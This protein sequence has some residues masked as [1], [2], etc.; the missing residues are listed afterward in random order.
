[1]DLSPEI[2]AALKAKASQL[3]TPQGMTPVSDYSVG[4]VSPDILSALKAKASQISQPSLTAN[5]KSLGRIASVGQGLFGGFLDEA[6]AGL[7][8]IPS[9]LGAVSS[10]N[11][12][13]LSISDIYKEELAKGRAG[14][15]FYKE[16]D[17]GASTALEVGGSL[18]SPINKIGA[19]AKGLFGLAKAGALQSGIYG[20]GNAEGNENILGE[21]LRSAGIGGGISGSLGLAG[22]IAKSVG[23]TAGKLAKSTENALIGIQYSDIKNSLNKDIRARG[24]DID[25][26]PIEKAIDRLSKKGIIKAGDHIDNLK[27]VESSVE[28]LS[29]DLGSLYKSIDSKQTDFIEP[30][31]NH[32]DEFIGKLDP[33][34]KKQ[35]LMEF[36]KL[37]ADQLGSNSLYSDWANT[38]SSLNKQG[39]NTLGLQGSDAFTPELKKFMARD[40]NEALQAELNK[41][42][43]SGLKDQVIATKQGLSDG[44]KT[45][46][47]LSKAAAREKSTTPD[48]FITSLMRTSGGYGVPILAGA[49]AGDASGMGVIPGALAGLALRSNAGKKGIVKILQ[50]VNSSG[51]PLAQLAQMVAKPAGQVARVVGLQDSESS[52]QGDRSALSQSS[53]LTSSEINNRQADRILDP[54]MESKNTQTERGESISSFDQLKKLMSNHNLKT[55]AKK[56]ENKSI[57]VNS[58]RKAGITDP[59]EFKQFMA[60]MEHESAG[61]GSMVERGSGEKYEGRKDLGNTQKGDGERFKGRGFIQL[62]GR[63][64]YERYGQ[65]IGIDLVKN[66]QFAEDPEVAAMIA[67]EYWKDRVKSKVTDFK[68]VKA[69][70]KAINGGYN[71]LDDRMARLSKYDDETVLALLQQIAEGKVA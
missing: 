2:I 22:K 31:F 14:L 43:Y 41:P 20:A 46:E 21:T 64:N 63:D 27:N 19:G 13:E 29:K 7:S 59:D 32:V 56:E 54:R 67:I 1:M 42:H 62:T 40:I 3:G 70:T 50:G 66:P 24:F 36:N 39:A 23:N 15:D 53:S 16:Q 30:S 44:F 68:D 55:N 58:L 49:Y 65:K 48:S 33:T 4:R 71:G 38:A 8:A 6:N 69:V 57:L 26:S 11:P 60:Q 37:K 52:S 9:W 51:D 45:Q 25:D 5:Q 28:S 12:E 61:F 17:D 10:G 34:S 18:L 35:M 47:V